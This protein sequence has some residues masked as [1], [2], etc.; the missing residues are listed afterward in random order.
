MQEPAEKEAYRERKQDQERPGH[1]DG[2]DQEGHVHGGHILNGEEQRKAGERDD[3]DQVEVAHTLAR[4]EMLSGRPDSTRRAHAC[5]APRQ[6]SLPE[7]PG[8]PIPRMLRAAAYRREP[9]FRWVMAAGS[10]MRH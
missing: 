8:G 6:T 4:G 7:L 3:Q 10:A 1:R 5:T 9:P 2:P